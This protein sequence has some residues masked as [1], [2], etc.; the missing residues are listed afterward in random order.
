MKCPPRLITTLRALFDGET[1][2]YAS[3]IRIFVFL[4]YLREHTI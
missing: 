1:P 4:A 3:I 2:L